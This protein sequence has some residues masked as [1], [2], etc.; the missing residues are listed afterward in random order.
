MDKMQARSPDGNSLPAYLAV[1]N[2][3]LRGMIYPCLMTIADFDKQPRGPH[4]FDWWVGRQRI[5]TPLGLFSVEFQMLDDDDTNPSDDEM[6]R[7]ASGLVTYTGSHGEFILDI[8]FGYYLLAA[9]E[10]DWMEDCGIPRGLPRNRI[11]DYVREDRSLV[12]ARHLNWDQPYTTS[13]H[14]VPLWDEEHAL[15]LEFRDG[16]IV[17]ANDSQF[18]LEAGVLRWND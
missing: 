12:V 7:R 3:R 17:A 11:A 2:S 10:R 5:A 14:V 15:S 9:E 1:P 8:V 18:R 16:A 4:L 6:L 13:I